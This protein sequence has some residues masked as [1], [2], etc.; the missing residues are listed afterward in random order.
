MSPHT[1][2]TDYEA[3]TCPL[4]FPELRCDRPRAGMPDAERREPLDFEESTC[5]APGYLDPL[6]PGEVSVRCALIQDHPDPTRHRGYILAEWRDDGR[7]VHSAGE[8][9]AADTAVFTGRGA[10]QQDPAGTH[11]EVASWP[12]PCLPTGNPRHAPA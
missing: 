12:V 4:C 1:H 11:G 2:D 8:A 9:L 5:G 7:Q 3:D 10:C 6:H